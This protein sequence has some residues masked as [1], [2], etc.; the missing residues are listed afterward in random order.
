MALMSRLL[1]KTY[2]LVL[3][4]NLEI[5]KV[6]SS[7]ALKNDGGRGAQVGMGKSITVAPTTDTKK[8]GGGCC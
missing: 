2:W 8:A 5:Y 7:E 1:F 3:F 4:T 6:V